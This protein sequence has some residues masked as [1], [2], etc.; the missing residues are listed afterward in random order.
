MAWLPDR[1]TGRPRKVVAHDFSL[2]PDHG[3][4][5]SQSEH[6]CR[7]NSEWNIPGP[8]HH[9]MSRAKGKANLFRGDADR[10]DFLKTRAEVCRDAGGVVRA[11]TLCA[12]GL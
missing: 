6:G 3:A 10:Q 8:L 7:V 11:L 5:F 12:I 1:K 9:L 2:A 4:G